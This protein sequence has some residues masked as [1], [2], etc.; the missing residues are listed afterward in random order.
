M[1]DRTK[2]DRWCDAVLEAGWLAALVV[3]PLFFNVFSSR[4]FE[5]DKISLVRTIALSMI[6]VWLIKI[7]N[8]G[9]A[10]LPA[11]NGTGRE[12]SAQAVQ[13][14]NWR[15]W[16]RNPFFIPVVLVIAAY[17]I[18]TVFSVAVFVSWFG[19][20]QRL[21]GAYSFLAYVTIG[22]L[23]AATLRRPEQIRRVQHVVIIVSLAASL[24]GI[25]QHYRL[26]PL[27]WGGDVT[28]RIAGNAGNAIFL[29][30]YLIMGFFLTLE[31]TFSSF[32]RLARS[33][34]FYPTTQPGAPAEGFD[35]QDWQTAVAGGAYL[36]V[37]FVI[38]AAIVWTGSRGPWIGWG[39]G[40]YLFVLIALSAL[41]PRAYKGLTAGW[42]ALGVGG[43]VLVILA[44]TLP[45][46][47][48]FR[49]IP[50]VGRVGTILDLNE[51]T[52]LV[53]TL[54]WE[55]ATELVA[56]HA[57]L[58]FPDGEKDGVNI[59][60]PLI[61]YGPEAMWIAYN[62]FYPPDL[63][64]IEARNASPDRSHNETWDSLVITGMFG[65]LA[66]I[67]VFIS[68]FYWSLRWLGL[69]RGR[70][71]N[72]LFAVLLVIFSILW[73]AALFAYDGGR[74]RLFGVAV[75]FGI[76][77]G[78]VVYITVAAFMHSDIRPDR[79]E[80]P[81]Q[82]VILAFLTAIVAHYL[83]IH[84]G[85]A[86]GA[87][88]TTFWVFTAALMVTGMGLSQVLS[89]DFVDVADAVEP[90][91]PAPSVSGK[92]GKPR[93][94][95]PAPVRRPRK[96]TSTF[97][98]LPAT[99]LTDVLVF[100]TFVYIYTT[101]ST[102]SKDALGILFSSVMQR[103]V[104]NALVF[105]PFVFTVV[106]FFTWLIAATIGLAAESLSHRQA[107]PAGWWVRGYLL[108]ALIVWGSW[109]V[110][111]LIQGFRLVPP[112]ATA[113]MTN[114]EFLN[115]Q[116]ERVAGHFGFYTF[117]VV[118]WMLVAGTVFAW[119][120]LRDRTLAVVGRPL[121]A[122]ITGVA[123]AAVAIFFVITVNVNLV[124]ADIIYKQGQQF[125]QANNWISSIEL[126]RRALASRKTEDQY[127]LFLGRALLE[128]AKVAQTT[129]T[130]ALPETATL[131]DVL[132]LTS[133]QVAQMSRGELLRAAEVVL[134]DAQNVNPLNTDHTA[135]LARLYRTWADLVAD[136]PAQRQIILEKSIAMY[137]KAVMLSPNAAH[138][139]NERGNAFLADGRND[140]ALTSYQKSLSI[141]NLFDQTYLLTAD[142]LDRTGQ[143][144]TLAS[145]LNQGIDIFTKSNNPG[146]V[147]QLLSYMS[148][149]QARSGDL[150]GAAATNQRMLEL[151]PGNIGALRNLAII[152]RDLGK[153][154]DA[155]N[156]L[157]QAIAAAGGNVADLKPLLQFAAELYQA[158]G[159]T[160]QMAAQY[161]T[162]VQL[163]PTDLNALINLA[164]LYTALADDAKLIDTEQKLIAL[165]PQNYQYPLGMAQA[166][167]RQGRIQEALIAAQQARALAPEDQKPAIQELITQLGGQ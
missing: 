107:A 61:G 162:I 53:R 19:S 90:T 44:N 49:D 155:M 38:T 144:Q 146:V 132:R 126:Y 111:G 127:M 122:A 100:L 22:G 129:G 65:F 28:A 50:Y 159:D 86:I 120:W 108:H 153:P 2:L 57:P 140:E 39:I 166:L 85:I 26:D 79:K 165:D 135:N 99:V 93:Q 46:L 62:G 88:R 98:L 112:E 152:S 52:N 11:Y 15:G 41:R 33:E 45:A 123:A 164:N 59:V 24:Y 114:P 31:R 89:R 119:P 139:W 43:T 80:L 82:L 97:P 78:Y 150:A 71:D 34:L 72:I 68:I 143:T 161:E 37:L 118:V 133:D 87:T 17:L 8:G 103:T 55:G 104:D 64:H 25:L 131:D 142:L 7:A 32:V 94:V 141:D 149:A 9:Y 84:F 1:L 136:D 75:P 10:W 36:F 23:T 29:G 73:T 92:K 157:N 20:Y 18:S 40:L 106:L 156:Y 96:Q 91:A 13:G 113:G 117:V 148:V 48:F 42:V 81:R 130:Y 147:S 163:D 14:A 21:Q 74:T 109:L 27:P 101:N 145:L 160:A 5:P 66:Y 128:Q 124:S 77:F 51:G 138:L 56:P 102:G 95:P 167:A 134:L 12:E 6:V 121:W 115:L 83:E 16:V 110:Y 105:S 76:I 67:A 3:A 63:A 70:R 47:S 158:Q 116:L 4:V 60:R 151:M 137:D 125:D 69:V 35:R 54:I 58:T 30:A 154:E